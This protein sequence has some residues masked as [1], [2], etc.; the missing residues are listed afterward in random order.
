MPPREEP[1]AAFT[2]GSTAHEAFEAFTKDRRDCGFRSNP[3]T[4]FAP[5]RS[6]VSEVSDH[7]PVRPSA[8]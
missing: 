4:R 8:R 3:I 7:P 5:I 2:F 1:V 6:V